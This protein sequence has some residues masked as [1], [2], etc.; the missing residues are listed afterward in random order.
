[1]T[2]SFFCV[3][4]KVYYTDVIKACVST[5]PLLPVHTLCCSNT[6]LRLLSNS[7]SLPCHRHTLHLLR[8]FFTCDLC[9][10]SFPT[11]SC[12][13]CRSVYLDHTVLHAGFLLWWSCQ[14]FLISE[15]ASVLL[16]AEFH[17]LATRGRQRQG[18]RTALRATWQTCPPP[19][20]QRRWH[21]PRG[22][23]GCAKD[24]CLKMHYIIPPLIW[25]YIS[26]A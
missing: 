10:M 3:T 26:A 24:K 1:M 20:S 6:N 8:Q 15:F 13:Q 23:R 19:H 11:M 18:E 9:F 14:H 4:V 7:S 22:D 25:S 5:S 16:D 21:H 17:S 12:S 2:I